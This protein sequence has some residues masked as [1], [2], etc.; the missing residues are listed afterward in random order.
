MEANIKKLFSE[1][2]KSKSVHQISMRPLNPQTERFS[3]VFL[4]LILFSRFDG[5]TETGFNF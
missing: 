3:R 5:F 1:K 2:L 4:V